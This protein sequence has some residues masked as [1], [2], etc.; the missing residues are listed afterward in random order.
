MKDK[1]ALIDFQKKTKTFYTQNDS[2]KHKLEMVFYLLEIYRNFL[3]PDPRRKDF[4]TDIAIRRVFSTILF[5]SQLSC[6]K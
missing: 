2:P 6:K 1:I 4:C 3:C 5:P